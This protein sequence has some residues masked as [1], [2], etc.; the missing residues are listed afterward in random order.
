MPTQVIKYRDTKVDAERTVAELGALIKRYG[1]SRFEQSWEPDGC[2]GGVR[3]AVRHE[4]LGELPV[5]LTARTEQ[6]RRIMLDAGLW[7]SYSPAD[8][9]RKITVQ[10]ERVAWRHIKDT[11]EQLLLAVQLGLRT[12]PEA[13]MADVELYDRERGEL[14]RMGEYLE[15][16]ASAGPD[17]LELTTTAAAAEDRRAIALPAGE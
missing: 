5:S 7:K 12:L 16:R 11:T 3:F 9:E 2:V 14:V 10:S 13:F 1:G 17:G 8:R 15:R 6:I 4:T